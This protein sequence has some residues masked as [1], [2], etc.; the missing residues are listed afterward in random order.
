MALVTELATEGGAPENRQLAGL[1]LKN[2]IVAQ[3]ASIHEAKIAKWTQCDNGMKDQ[4]RA[5]VST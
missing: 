2:V 1:F 3:D 5:G 4:I